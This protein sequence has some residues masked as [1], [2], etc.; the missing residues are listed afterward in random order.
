MLRTSSGV[1]IAIS[2]TL[3]LNGCTSTPSALQVENQTDALTSA[4]SEASGVL[5]W[6][7]AD[8]DLSDMPSG[9]YGDTQHCSA[10][11]TSWLTAHADRI[12]SSQKVRFTN[13]SD[14]PQTVTLDTAPSPSTNESEYQRPRQGAIVQCGLLSLAEKPGAGE[15]VWHDVVYDLTKDTNADATTTDQ[16]SPFSVTLPPGGTVGAFIL[17]TGER[18]FSGSLRA[19]VSP[20]NGDAQAIP[21]LLRGSLQSSF[22]WPGIDPESSLLVYVKGAELHCN[23]GGDFNSDEPCSPVQISTLLQQ[24]TSA[25]EDDQIPPEISGKWCTIS[26]DECIDLATERSEH[27]N[28]FV[29]KQSDAYSGRGGGFK[30]CLDGDLDR[31]TDG[32]LE[33]EC[34]M[35]AS[36]FIDYYPLGSQWDCGSQLEEWGLPS[37][38]PD[39]SDYHDVAKERIVIRPNHQQDAV[40]HDSPPMYRVDQ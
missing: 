8:T 6:L 38:D 23:I 13:V 20:P 32:Q 33:R 17:L 18:P 22:D 12:S 19:S 29:Q 27:P 25:R 11:M 36:M 3:A 7:P 24:M 14:E 9:D 34:S 28:L 35:A 2:L 37:C 10:G 15:I 21:I 30:V 1:V 26:Q 40:Y 5:Y 4:Q 31:I 39:Y 16:K